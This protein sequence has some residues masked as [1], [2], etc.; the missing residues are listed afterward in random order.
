MMSGRERLIRNNAFFTAS[1][2]MLLSFM[3]IPVAGAIGAAIT[4]STSLIVMNIIS[5]FL[6]Y[7]N[8][9]ISIL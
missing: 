2:C 8:L 9:G 3:L 5:L 6:V 4:V 7:K 1:I